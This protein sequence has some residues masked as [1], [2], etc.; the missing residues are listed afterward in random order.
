MVAH[1]LDMSTS[2]VM[3]F[4]KTL[5]AHR[6]VQ[7]QFGKRSVKKRYV[8]LLDGQLTAMKGTIDLPLRGDLND[9][10]RQIVCHRNG[11][12]AQSHYEAITERDGRTLLYF[13]PVTG[14]THQLRVHAAHPEGLG[15]PIV[16]DDLYGS[17]ADRLYLHAEELT[18]RH[19]VTKAVVSFTA[20]HP[21]GSREI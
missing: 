13:Y 6:A 9:R 16:G 1:R 15:V 4:T 8:A 21:F 10:P 20:P 18:L 19:P 2:G 14:R 17:A 5:A 12:P 3:V 7:R 11:K